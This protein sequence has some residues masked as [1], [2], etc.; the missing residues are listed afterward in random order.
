MN[1]NLG[2]S[3]AYGATLA[4]LAVALLAAGAFVA[5]AS[6]HA[7][8]Y[9]I[10]GLVTDDAANNDPNGL[11]ASLGLPPAAHIDPNLVNPWGVSFTPTSPYWV[12]D[13]NSGFSTLYTA[14]GVQV[15]PPRLLR[16]PTLPVP[17]TRPA[18]C[19]TIRTSSS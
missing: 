14:A 4:N 3:R 10:T 12:S 1:R 18:R 13:N 19:S 8:T 7:S 15:T 5:A 11:L 2:H 16:S 9:Q 6:A 17:R